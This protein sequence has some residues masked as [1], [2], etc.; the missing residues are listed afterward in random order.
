MEY[1][2]TFPGLGRQRRV[3]SPLNQCEL[4]V[5]WLRLFSH[6]RLQPPDSQKKEACFLIHY[7]TLTFEKSY[8]ENPIV[9][10][11]KSCRLDDTVVHTMHIKVPQP[12][13]V[14]ETLGWC[15]FAAATEAG[16]ESEVKRA[17]QEA[18]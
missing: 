15:Y 18:S 16:P 17:R 12:M 4:V 14:Y 1:V 10:E 13:W 5:F 6:D 3:A 11:R 8:S 9:W 7:F 2:K